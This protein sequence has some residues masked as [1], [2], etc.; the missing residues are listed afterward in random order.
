[1]IPSIAIIG[2]KTGEGNE[3]PVCGKTH[4]YSNP[5]RVAFR[6]HRELGTYVSASV[7]SG[8]MCHP[9]ETGKPFDTCNPAGNFFQS[10]ARSADTHGLIGGLLPAGRRGFNFSRCFQAPGSLIPGFG[11][12]LKT[13]QKSSRCFTNAF[14]SVSLLLSMPMKVSKGS[15]NGTKNL[16][17]IRQKSFRE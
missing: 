6:R 8:R 4:S 16:F 5:M 14:H 2:R 3:A 17:Q 15:G 9:L 10:V 1:M 7:A 13:L 12:A 11:R